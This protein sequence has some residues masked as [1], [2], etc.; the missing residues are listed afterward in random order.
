MIIDAFN[1]PNP[2][3]DEPGCS[4]VKNAYRK[5]VVIYVGISEVGRRMLADTLNEPD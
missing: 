4:I 5:L 3:A 2:I 1:G